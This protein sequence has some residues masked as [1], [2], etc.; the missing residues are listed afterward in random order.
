MLCLVREQTILA[1]P[2]LD[3][4]LSMSLICVAHSR[5]VALLPV[6]EG[7]IPCMGIPRFPSK[8]SCVSTLIY[9]R[10]LEPSFD[11]ICVQYRLRLEGAFS[12]YMGNQ[13]G[14]IGG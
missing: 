7:T 11:R 12:R 6:L 1:F 14:L 9:M 10:P 3:D 4:V 2:W 8:V 5:H 13:M